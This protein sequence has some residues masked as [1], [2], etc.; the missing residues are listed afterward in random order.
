MV[1]HLSIAYLNPPAYLLPPPGMVFS[2][3]GTH[4]SL[5]LAAY[6]HTLSIA[7][8]GFMC[9][10]V[11][12]LLLAGLVVYSTHARAYITPF[13]V[14][15]KSIPTIALA[16]LLIIWFGFSITT[17]VLIVVLIC[18][19]PLYLGALKGLRTVDP[20]T[21]LLFKS[22]RASRL[23]TFFHLR[24]PSALP[25]LFPAIKVS[26]LLAVTGAFFAEFIGSQ[27]GIGNLLL[28]AL[29]TFNSVQLYAGLLITILGG[30]VL[31][32]ALSLLERTIV[33]WQKQD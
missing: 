16:P 28:T 13:L 12:T 22:L 29:H 26:A 27:Q 24:L 6:G 10:F 5:Y 14:I 19:M 15:L 7:F 32:G 4:L 2:E 30:L 11:G 23:K 25:F 1:W 3:L 20:D 18:G 33:F 31:F 21:L 8:I 9:A 17:K